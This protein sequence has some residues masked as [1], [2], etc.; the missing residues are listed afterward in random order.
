VPEPVGPNRNLGGL[1][2]GVGDAMLSASVAGAQSMG[3][4]SEEATKLNKSTGDALGE[5][6][7]F[8]DVAAAEMAKRRARDDAARKKITDAIN[9]ANMR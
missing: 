4:L 3:R 6:V 7:K 2:F 8:A 1:P 5:I 9:A